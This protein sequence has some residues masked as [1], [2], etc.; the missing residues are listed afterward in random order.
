MQALRSILALTDFSVHARHPSERAAWLAAG[1]AL[2]LR[3]RRGVELPGL[4]RV[5]RLGGGR[6]QRLFPAP[7]GDRSVMGADRQSPVGGACATLGL[8]SGPERFMNRPRVAS[9]VSTR[10]APRTVAPRSRGRP[11]AAAASA[12]R[13]SSA[14][15]G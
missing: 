14:G 13:T 5:P 12:R 3:L 4:Y 9:E 7:R 1:H 2:P 15:M 6:S 10:V 8:I 11:V